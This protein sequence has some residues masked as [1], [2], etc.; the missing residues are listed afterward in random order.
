MSDL[1]LFDGGARTR[2]I[3]E[4]QECARR[5]EEL[6]GE[7]AEQ[8]LTDQARRCRAAVDEPADNGD[9]DLGAESGAGVGVLN[10]GVKQRLAER[11]NRIC[12][13]Y[14]TTMLP[15]TTLNAST[16]D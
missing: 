14:S 4:E 11:A 1:E 13:S 9:T 7:V 15:T 2:W 12:V 6:Q 3:I 16:P 5:G 10:N 8:V